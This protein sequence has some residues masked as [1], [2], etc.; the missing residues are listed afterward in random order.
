[1]SDVML[2]VALAIICKIKFGRREIIRLQKLVIF[3][4]TNLLN[5]LGKLRLNSGDWF[6]YLRMDE[7]TYM[8]LLQK[9]IPHIEK[10]DA[11]MRRAL[12]SVLIFIS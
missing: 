11:V 2:Y 6:N 9:I 7:A 10:S 1:M 12:D 8:E 4:H 3:S 5:L